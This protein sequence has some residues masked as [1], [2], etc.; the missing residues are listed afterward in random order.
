MSL[1]VSHLQGH[2]PATP[3]ASFLQLEHP[4]F[5]QLPYAAG[6]ADSEYLL[7]AK[8]EH[9]QTH[10]AGPSLSSQKP[11]VFKCDTCE[12][13]FAKPS[14]LER[15]S[16]IHTGERPFHCTL[17]EKAFNQKSALQ[18]HMKKHTGERPYKCAYCVMGFTQKSNMK[19]HM[20]R[21]HSYAVRTVI[22]Q[23]T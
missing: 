4:Y 3:D 1:A 6:L 14:Q 13:A 2:S 7:Y 18:V 17:C 23:C 22:V 21:A 11:R 16:R 20:K 5:I 8:I 12:K 10:Q 19:L 9:M 15:H